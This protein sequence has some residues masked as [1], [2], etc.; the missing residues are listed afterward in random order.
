MCAA[1]A[2]QFPELDRHKKPIKLSSYA[3]NF[4]N[5]IMDKDPLQ[6]A[7]LPPRQHIAHTAM[8][9]AV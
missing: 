2:A 1:V 8:S 3:K 9:T 6:V 7:S 5:K 4:L